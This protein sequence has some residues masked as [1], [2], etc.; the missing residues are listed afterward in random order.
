MECKLYIYSCVILLMR[1]KINTT[2]VSTVFTRL[3]RYIVI[4]LL[5][6]FPTKHLCTILN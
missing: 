2:V 3:Q 6:Q 4:F 5:G 1:F